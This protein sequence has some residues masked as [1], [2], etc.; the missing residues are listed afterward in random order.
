[1]KGFLH[2]LLDLIE[3]VTG[4]AVSADPAQQPTPADRI[5]SLRDQ[6][7]ALDAPAPAPAEAPAAEPVEDPR[8]AEIAAL[9]ARLAALERPAEAPA[10]APATEAPA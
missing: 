4:L 9:K 6:V 5:A 10:A 2:E 3:H 1:M 7:D 8:D